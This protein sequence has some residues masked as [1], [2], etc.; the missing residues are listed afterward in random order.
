[1]NLFYGSN[2]VIDK[3]EALTRL[4]RERPPWLD[5]VDRCRDRLL[6][7]RASVAAPGHRGHHGLGAVLGLN[8]VL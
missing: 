8:P 5:E 2:Y 4:D 1:M 6:G 3:F 7:G